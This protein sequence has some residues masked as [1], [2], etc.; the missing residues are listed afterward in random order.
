MSISL[1]LSNALTGLTANGKQLEIAANNIANAATDGYGRQSAVLGSQIAGGF[2]NGVRIVDVE[3]AIDPAFSQV[4]RDADGQLAGEDAVFDAVRR[5]E[6][7]LGTSEDTDGLQSRATALETSLRQLADTPESAPRQELAVR[8]ADDLAKEFNAVANEATRLREAADRDIATSVAAV[9]DALTKIARLNR[10][11]QVFDASGRETAALI[12]ERERELDIVA[13]IIPTRET[14]RDNGVVELR[15]VQGLP[16]ADVRAQQL[17][18]TPTPVITPFMEYAGGTGALSGVTLNGKDISPAA[19]GNQTIDGGRLAGLFQVRDEVIPEF[20]SQLDSLAAN[21]ISRFDDPA[22]D[23]TRLATDPGLFTD[24]GA[25]F[26]PLDPTGIA[27][28]IQ[29][30][31][32]ADPV[33]GGDATRLRDGI[34]AVAAGP[35]GN[36]TVPRAMLDALTALQNATA[37]PGLTGNFS[38]NQR[39]AGVME[40]VATDRVRLEGQVAALSSARTAIATEEADLLGVDTDQELQDLIRIEQ[41]YAA[42]A[43]VITTAQDMLDQLLRF[44]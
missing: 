40:L 16:L 41:A 35:T 21:L 34:G 29:I 39:I 31:P 6:T 23:P 27:G 9:N 2:A 3:R 14:R 13:Q 28:R 7:A 5:L 32:L 36:G 30:N 37:T 44:R 8:A 43:Q 24:G 18:F 33:Q 42:N 15:T 19:P 22:V 26:D 1:A 17:E 4:R 20:Q 25:L 10:Q 38:F 12:D 11:I